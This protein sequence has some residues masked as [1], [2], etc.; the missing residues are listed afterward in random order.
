M[1][2][3]PGTLDITARTYSVLNT[4][5]FIRP[6]IAVSSHSFIPQQLQDQ[7]WLPHLGMETGPI[8]V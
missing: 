1:Y 2:P 4:Q 5:K 6:L 8:S 7:E 3:N